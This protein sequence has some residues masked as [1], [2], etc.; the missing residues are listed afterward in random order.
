M[1]FVLAAVDPANPQSP[2]NI[3]QSGG[4]LGYTS[5]SALPGLAYGYLGIGLDVYG[6]YSNASYQGST[7]TNPAYISTTT[8]VPGQVVVRGPGNGTV[9]YC[10]INSTATT[11]LPSSPPAGGHPNGCPGPG[12]HQPH[13]H[14]PHDRRQPGDPGQQ[15]PDPGHPRERCDQD[16]NGHTPHGSRS[17]CIRRAG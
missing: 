7:C 13:Q 14:G 12:R 3:G 15:L 6:N 4:A 11:R 9:G 2:A 1:S 17:A 5:F 16:P 10:A 8:R